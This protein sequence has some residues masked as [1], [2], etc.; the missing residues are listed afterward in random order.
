MLD[1]D[2]FS[3]INDT[4]GQ[5]VGDSLLKEVAG[6]LQMCLR[7]GR[8]G[9]EQSDG[10]VAT[11]DFQATLDQTLFLR[12]GGVV[13]AWLSPNGGNLTG[14]LMPMKD[15]GAFADEL[16]LAIFGRR[17]GADEQKLIAGFLERHAADRA[18]ALPELGWAL[19]SAAEFRFNH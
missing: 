16:Y 10:E 12:N 6:R 17:P 19:L 4:Q 11:D 18:T 13:R 15:A 5:A 8:R 2:N 9:F 14:R 7:D 3:R 1:V